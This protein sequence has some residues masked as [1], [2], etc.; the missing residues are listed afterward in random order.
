MST[1]AEK[2]APAQTEHGRS[3]AATYVVAIAGNPNS[4]KTSIFNRMTGSNQRV[5][6]YPGVT[7]EIKEGRAA[8]NGA[9]LRLV[10]LP[11]TYS[12]TA[13]SQEEVV[14]RNFIIDRN[15]GVVV[16]VVDASNLERNL[17]LAVQLME[18]GT[19]LVMALNMVDLAAKRG[20]TFDTEK[21]SRLLGAPVVSTVGS[22]GEGIDEL[23]GASVG[24]CRTGGRPSLVTYGHEVEAEVE[25]L[26][27]VIDECGALN[28][29]YS[30]RWLAVKLIEGDE[31]VVQQVAGLGADGIRVRGAAGGAAGAIEAH[32]GESASAIIAERRYGFAAGIV[33]ECVASSGEARQNLTD[34]LDAIVC[35]RVLGPAVLAGVVFSLFV[36]V[37]GVAQEWAWIPFPWS[38][39]KWVSPTG[40]LEWLFAGA[41]GLVAPLEPTMPVLHSLVNDGII[42]GVGGVIGFVPLI[43][44]M[45]MFIAVLE[46]TG[47]MAR[48]AF[49]L[50]RL[51]KVFGL[52]GKSVLALIV[53]GGLGA[54]GCAVPGVMAT[55]TLRDEKDRLV[56]M[57]VAPFMNCGAKLPVYAMLIAA[58]FS[59]N[60]AGMMF[61]LWVLSWCV[62]LGAAWTLRKLLVKGD[63]TPFVMELPA[64]HVPTIRGVVMHTWSRTWM[65]VKKAGTIIL[66]VSLVLWALMYFPTLDDATT[67]AF[68]ARIAAAKE[69]GDENLVQR[70]DNERA[71][72]HLAGSV[73]GRLGGLLLPISRLA[74]FN[75]ARVNIALV[76]GWA[77]KEVVVSTLGT[78]YSMGEID[79]GDPKQLAE[80]LAGSD[81]WSPLQAFALLVFVM[82]YAPCLT[83]V[84][85][86]KRESGTWK[87]AAFATAY[88][89]ALAFVLA[90]GVF[91]IGR[92]VLPMFG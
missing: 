42:G 52:Q 30:S 9:G 53:S 12:L 63:R 11:G 18:I 3:A 27:K 26:A 92:L 78:A 75:D 17:Y 1:I 22:K 44:A 7:V 51:L 71:G 40:L 39:D 41:S 48:V 43:A 67:A 86:I 4:G 24:A 59:G 36:L 21:M 13:Y 69:A 46:D 88:A 62:A 68:D 34:T 82:V 50:D 56:T 65:Y 54:G 80:R 19:P 10:D 61:L 14:A 6:N 72:A 16:D 47:Y 84:A 91:Q 55:R 29:R 77:A 83:T 79:A 60:R 32:F 25:K 64:Y 90:V 28:A 66:A 37:F 85:V 31:A 74:G 87:W 8:A 2:P 89:T 15:P 23:L 35:N 57:L 70:I 76:G 5:G 33:R 58:F 20:L 73:A 45:F 38:E 49:I 81:D